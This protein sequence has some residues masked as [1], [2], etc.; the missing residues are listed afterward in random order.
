MSKSFDVQWCRSQFPALA[1]EVAGQPAVFFD[2]PAGSHVS[3]R[4]IEAVAEYLTR[5]NANHGGLFQ[6]SRQSNRTATAQ[7]SSPKNRE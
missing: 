2:G 5:Y 1:T 6:T 4:V 7:A 3:R